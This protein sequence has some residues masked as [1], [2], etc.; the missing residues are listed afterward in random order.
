M[1]DLNSET[2]IDYA[3]L[4]GAGPAAP[5]WV[6]GVHARL[7]ALVL[8]AL[9]PALGFSAILAIRAATVDRTTLEAR[10]HDLAAILANRLEREM[11]AS[12]G[13]LQG[14][15]A[16]PHL[17]D[18]DLASFYRQAVATPKRDGEVIVLFEPS[19]QIVFDT[20]RPLGT[21][22]PRRT[23][24][25][26]LRPV[27][28]RGEITV[29]GV[30]PSSVNTKLVFGIT[31]PVK[32]GNEVIYGLAFATLLEEVCGP[33]LAN[34]GAPSDWGAAI[35]DQHGV[36]AGHLKY[37]PERVGTRAE[38]EMAAAIAAAPRGGVYITTPGGQP[39]YAAWKRSE[40][41]GWT[42]AVGVP[43]A[44]LF[45]P[46]H[47]TLWLL[48][49]AGV[50]VLALSILL[51]W[52]GARRI[53]TPILRLRASAQALARREALPPP[54]DDMHLNETDVVEQ[55]LAA[56]A[57]DLRRHEAER[58]STEQRLRASEQRLALLAREVDHRAKNML[59]V[60]QTLVRRTHADSVAA[61]KDLVTGRIAALARV[62][63]LLSS[64]R[65][66]GADL[67]R[68]VEE[69]FAPY[70]RPGGARVRVDGP[71]LALVPAAAQSIA[72]AVHELATNAVKYGALSVPEGRLTV[73]W[74]I[75]GE[76]RVVL[77]WIEEG[78]PPMVRPLR[79]G[80]GLGVIERAVRF[81][82]DG[83][84]RFDWRK[85]GLVCEITLPGRQLA[86]RA[87]PQ[88]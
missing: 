38:P 84:I 77:R 49:A 19:G 16:S 2:N 54:R 52:M 15:A 72:M 51:A 4:V 60:V 28:E 5:R 57:N 39:I 67:R 35:F 58:D 32:R 59:A 40:V 17:Q 71:A 1:M 64:S 22:L 48:A 21:P 83:E 29:S 61:L 45:A 63:T 44:A 66:E 14:L 31:V 20:V 9:L 47:R 13:M 23:D 81:Q 42:A 6:S 76:G 11:A 65:W 10:A 37:A 33:A 41:S 69:E 53:A 18:R 7:L 27:F 82:L 68:L 50:A 85:E 88:D 3:A 30:L 73:D 12:I 78:G 26:P 87:P 74:H 36:F 25:T 56:A 43:T 70:R 75:D 86:P 55:A 80:V 8:A 79:V 62:H 24:M 46:L 34:F